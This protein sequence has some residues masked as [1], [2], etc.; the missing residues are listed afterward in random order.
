MRESIFEHQKSNLDRNIS[1]YKEL[2]TENPKDSY[3]EVLE[4]KIK[5]R[6]EISYDNIRLFFNGQELY[7][8]KYFADYNIIS[9]SMC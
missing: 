6:N 2:L 1:F 8:N 9:V 7:D 3:S 4:E 5:E